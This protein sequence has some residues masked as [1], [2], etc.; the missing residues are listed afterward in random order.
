[1]ILVLNCGSQSIKYKI[2]ND[3]LN[4]IE[5]NEFSINKENYKKKLEKI[6]NNCKNKD[7]QIIG[8]RI[9]HGG[10]YFFEPTKLTNKVIKKLKKISYLAPLHNPY[11]IL[12]IEIA[13]KI[14]KGVN[15]YGVFDTGFFKDL[16][17]VAKIYP[18]PKD[19]IK[20]FCIRRYG[21]HGISHE[22]ILL[23][24]SEL[25]KKPKNR[26]N[27]IS[28]HLGGGGS[29][30]AIKNGKP[31]DISMG[32]TPLE[33]I[34]MMTRS[35]DIDP[36]IVILLSKHFGTKKTYE[37]LNKKSGLFSI[38]GFKSMLE[39]LK[40]KNENKKCKLAFDIY[41]YRIKKYIGAYYS[42]LGKLDAVVFTGNIGAGKRETRDAICKGL[43][44]LKKAKVLSIKTDEEY[45]I[46]KKIKCFI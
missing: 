12:G 19:I 9:V 6:L 15:N 8:H 14:F 31:I 5:S 2:F 17:L 25:L 11:N 13:K 35:G 46:A 32:Y 40:R 29:I 37:I 4:I 26:L 23:K 30:C 39:I 18:L 24:T 33:G 38:C 1:M 20:N 10:K 42:I 36:G 16:P 44:F 27:I 45:L 7:I 41:I 22:Y 43:F 28:C 21:F 3:K 34:T